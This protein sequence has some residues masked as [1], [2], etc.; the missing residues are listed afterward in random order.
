M[1]NENASQEKTLVGQDEFDY[2]ALEKLL[3]SELEA[4]MSDL[5]VLS[6]QQL[7]FGDPSS[8]GETVL[9]TVWEQFTNQIA[10]QAGKDFIEANNGLK[11]DLRDEAHIQTTDN[12]A[13]GKIASH[14]TEINYKNRLSFN[15]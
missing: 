2:D 10:I 14:N 8:L 9:N 13:K 15:K 7:R 6:E 12:F 5:D 4:E 1:A 3:E 11:L